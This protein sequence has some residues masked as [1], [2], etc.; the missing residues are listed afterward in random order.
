MRFGERGQC[1]FQF[2]LRLTDSPR[3]DR[4]R[5]KTNPLSRVLHSATPA[6][7]SVIA[8][9]AYGVGAIVFSIASASEP[10]A[11][12]DR[13]LNHS[14]SYEAPS[15]YASGSSSEA[16][17]PVAQEGTLP[18]LNVALPSAS[19]PR[20]PD[21]GLPTISGPVIALVID[22]L[23]LD[24]G[25]AQR[26]ADLGIPLTMAVLPYPD[27]AA[28]SAQL[29]V[30]AGN[31]VIVHLPMEPLGLADPGPHALQ[32]ALA[33][34]D[35][36][37]RTR[38][39]LA[40]VP[41]AVGLNNHMG[42]RFTQD[43]RAMRVALNAVRNEIPLFLDSM[44]TG[45]SRGAAVARGLGL[46]A[47]ERDIFLDHVIETQ[48]IEARLADAEHL[49][50]LRGWSIAIGH[51]HE[52]TMQALE[53]WTID[54]RSRGITFVTLTQLARHIESGQNPQIEASI[55]RQ[56]ISFQARLPQP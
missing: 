3:T 45:E 46:A 34:A 36:E 23:G 49:A 4:M 10:A 50:Q 31:D 7:A 52:E 2:N 38:W 22:D 27:E 24:L 1:G 29:G 32:L 33:D 12:P 20:S 35:L 56:T 19:S 43:P 16:Q 13:S 53:A 28:S 51:P 30:A 39:A 41:G 26:V 37:A 44:T 5:R 8:A 47:L 9:A 15:L 18:P 55:S 21:L 14:I 11:L 48:A 17:L 54:A 42:S 40:R 25:D 6:L